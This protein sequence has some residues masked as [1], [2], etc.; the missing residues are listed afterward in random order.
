MA[1]GWAV[2]LIMAL[3]GSSRG[4]QGAYEAFWVGSVLAA[5]FAAFALS[6]P[7]TPPLAKADAPGEGP[8]L[9]RDALAVARRPGMTGFLVAALCVHLTTPFIYQVIP[10][11]LES[12]GMPRAWISTAMTLGQCPEIAM[13]V[14]LPL[15]FRRLGTRWTLALGVA[16]WALRFGVLAAGSPL[17]LAVATIPLQGVGIACFTVAGQVYTDSQA[18][19]DLRASA[20]AIYTVATSG[21]G[22]FLG[23]LLAGAVVGRAGGDGRLAFLVPC[24]IDLT[25]IVY[26]CAGFRP[27]AATWDRAGASDLARPSRD[28][29][30]RTAFARVGTLVTESA[31]G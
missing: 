1:V 15:L 13:L 24:M 26:F 14:A 27:N 6:L 29:V 28:D 2:S 17:W 4:G 10:T 11:Y 20:Q 12:Q 31:D 7:H 3:S 25:L 18:P 30:V 8:A 19:V 5:A 22:A 16:A 9:W 23:S 21:L